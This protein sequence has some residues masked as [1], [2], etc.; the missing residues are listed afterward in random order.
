VNAVHSTNI[1]REIKENY[2]LE[3]IYNH[4]SSLNHLS[5][6]INSPLVSVARI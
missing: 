2:E 3:E 5:S 1:K 4:T 6:N